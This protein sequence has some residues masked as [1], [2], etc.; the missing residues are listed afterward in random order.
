[1]KQLTGFLLREYDAILYQTRVMT[2]YNFFLTLKIFFLYST[3]FKKIL[4]KR[5]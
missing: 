5:M 3:V 4:R 2:K 1:M